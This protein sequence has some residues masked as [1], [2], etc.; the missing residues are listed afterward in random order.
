MPVTADCIISASVSTDARLGRTHPDR[1][2]E[3]VDRDRALLL[4]T[5]C[6]ERRDRRDLVRRRSVF[7]PS[8]TARTASS[9]AARARSRCWA[10]VSSGTR[11]ARPPQP[12]PSGVSR[13]ISRPRSPLR[14]ILVSRSTTCFAVDEHDE[15]V[16]QEQVDGGVGLRVP[17]DR[18][19]PAAEI[20][21]S[22]APIRV[23]GSGPGRCPTDEGC[24]RATSSRTRIR[25]SSPER[26]PI[27]EARKRDGP[28]RVS[29]RCPIVD[30]H[31]GMALAQGLTEIQIVFFSV[32]CSNAS[33]PLSRP[34]KPDSL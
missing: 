4:R 27:R 11:P 18:L 31:C 19:A 15:A 9:T 21:R 22:S 2:G 12:P 16:R 29:G 26:D 3:Q 23:V 32:Y 17:V 34:P 14:W 28:G 8:R 33:R 7:G 5:Q 25:I 13:I 24:R 1:P 6:V 20:P 30:R 10:S